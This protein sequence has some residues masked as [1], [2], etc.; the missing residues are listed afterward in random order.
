MAT[1]ERA[2]TRFP[3]ELTKRVDALAAESRWTRATAI[4]VLVEEALAHRAR[5]A[6]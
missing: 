2:S 6:A 5:K 4:R 1:T 3:P